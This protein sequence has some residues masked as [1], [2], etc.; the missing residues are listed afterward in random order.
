MSVRI[1]PLADVH[2]QAV[3]GNDVEIGPFC[4]VGPHVVLGDGC[5]LDSHVTI[6][7]HTVV[8]GHN[9]FWPGSVI[10]AEPQDVGYSDSNTRVEIGDDNQFREG[11]TVNRGADKEDGVTRIGDRNFLM[12]NAHI[13]HNC[14]VFNNVILCNGVLLGGHV[15]VQDYAIVSGN[16]VVHHFATVGTSAFVSG[17]CRVPQDVPPF[18]LSAGSDNPQIATVNLVGMRRRGISEDTIRLIRQAYKLIFREHKP[19]AD[20]R[21]EFLDQLEGSLP[22][23]LAQLLHFIE[24]S[25]RGKNGRAREAVR[26]KDA[27]KHATVES[28]R[29]AA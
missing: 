11:V 8:G 21:N 19:L 9:R 4:V 18:M 26:F 7:G 14:H 3:L 2:P 12:A 17:G 28:P 13:A 20:A 25:A 5:I 24:Q 22:I 10:G 1:S 6:I 27:A 23:E 29:R 16:S 15:H